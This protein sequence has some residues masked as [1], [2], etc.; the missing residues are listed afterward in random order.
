MRHT[1][2]FKA[3]SLA[4]LGL[5]VFVIVPLASWAL[6]KPMRVIAP[7][8]AGVACSSAQICTDDVSQLA[9]ASGLSA[10]A[11]SFVSHHVGPLRAEPRVIFCATQSCADTFGLGARSAVTVGT[12]GTVIGPR[13]WKPY[14]VRHEL[15]HQLQAEKWGVASTLFKPSWLVEGMAYALSEDPRPALAEP[16]QTYR[17]QF[18]AWRDKLDHADMWAATQAF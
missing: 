4:R 12:V 16:W 13:A 9:I 1:Q 15:I 17:L 3:P 10:E 11:Q 5:I 18:I 8:L 7:G 2:F 14:Y 6:V